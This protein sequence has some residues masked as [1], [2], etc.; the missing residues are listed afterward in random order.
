MPKHYFKSTVC[1]L[2]H[3]HTTE[4]HPL[5]F[6]I[7]DRFKKFNKASA[8]EYVK[9][10]G[11]DWG[12]PV[13]DSTIWEYIDKTGIND[14]YNKDVLTSIVESKIPIITICMVSYRRYNTLAKTLERY[15][16][17]GVPINLLLW[18]NSYK[19]YTEHQL[20]HIKNICKK[21]Y[22]HDITYCNKNMGTGHPRNIMLSRAYKEYDTSYIMTTDDDI[23]YNSK[24]E[25][26]IAVSILDQIKYYQYGA[27]GIWC[28]PIY[29]SLYV[30]GK[31]LKNYI[32][33]KGFQSVDALGAATMVIKREVLDKC[34][35]D[36]E[37]KMGWVDT[38][39]SFQMRDNGYKLGLL[40]DDLWKP[41]NIADKSD[42][43]YRQARSDKN[44]KKL[45]SDRFT[46]KW[47]ITPVWSNG[48]DIGEFNVD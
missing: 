45:S 48:T 3:G 20:Q 18:L 31:E 36:P 34:N 32:P 16:S 46:K 9:Q 11:N 43:I 6:E 40:C 30:I 12:E 22:S 35:T 39:F 44:T 28:N 41:T 38:D 15:V 47:G 1:H 29:Y 26:F 4:K 37:Y 42:K 8:Q 24:E 2:Y 21:L 25:L 14:F 13:K 10:K 23:M 33:K 27:I 7:F 17:F 19:D 5:R